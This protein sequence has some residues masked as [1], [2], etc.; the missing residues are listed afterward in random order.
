MSDTEKKCSF[1]DSP[2]GIQ[3]KPEGAGEYKIPDF[4]KIIIDDT[5][6]L[7]NTR[8]LHKKLEE[9]FLEHEKAQKPLSLIMIDIDHFRQINCAVDHSEGDRALRESGILIKSIIRDCDIACRHGGDEFAIILTETGKKNAIETAKRIREAFQFRFH[10]YV[11]KIT[12]SV[13]VASYPEDAISRDGLIHAADKAVYTSQKE[14][15]NRVTAAPSLR[16]E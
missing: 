9:T 5:S 4:S 6:G 16:K 3:D 1:C 11:V 13:G 12:A 7:Y 14:G 10:D 8:Y 15:R 2:E